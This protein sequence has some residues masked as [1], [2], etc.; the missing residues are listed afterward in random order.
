MDALVPIFRSCCCIVH[1]RVCVCVLERLE[2]LPIEEKRKLYDCKRQYNT[3][4]DIPT[5]AEYFQQNQKRLLRSKSE[6]NTVSFDACM[7]MNGVMFAFFFKCELCILH[8]YLNINLG[9]GDI[10]D[11]FYI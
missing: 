7:T 9:Q 2:N 1:A 4:E 5:W 8:V 6:P 11:N 3:L 10:S